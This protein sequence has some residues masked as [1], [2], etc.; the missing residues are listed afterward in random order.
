MKTTTKFAIGAAAVIAVSAGVAGVTAY[1]VMQKNT[2]A[3]ASFYQAFD[4]AM[5]LRTAALDASS[6]QP[7][8]LTKA[9]ESSLNSVVHIMAVQ[10]S[11][12]QVVESQPDI[13]DF[14]SVTDADAS[15]RSRLRSSAV[16]ARG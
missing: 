13:F 2:S 10:R 9:A 7:V 8:D 3:N 15:V 5:P 6:M 16:S 11:K 14:F 1:A 12:T 4:A